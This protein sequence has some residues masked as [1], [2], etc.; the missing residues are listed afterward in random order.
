MVQ[1]LPLV[2]VDNEVREL[3][4]G[5]TLGGLTANGV[6][7]LSRVAAQALGGHRIVRSVDASLVDYA[8]QTNAAHGASVLGFTTGAAALGDP[9]QVQ[10]KGDLVHSGWNWVPNQPIWVGANGVPTQTPPDT[11]AAFDL[12]VAVAITATQ[13]YIEVEEVLYL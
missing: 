5:D 13:I 9:V 3:P 7:T 2:N 1:R 8:D 10:S 11:P 6:V 12:R 4:A